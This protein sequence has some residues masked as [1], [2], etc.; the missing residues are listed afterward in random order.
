[1]FSIREI[2]SKDEW[3]KFLDVANPHTFLHSWNWGEF[4]Q[5]LGYRVWHV[6]VYKNNILVAV[7]LAIAIF[8]RR[9]TFIFC[10][11][12]PIIMY[13][14]SCIRN[15]ELEK[16]LKILTGFLKN[17]AKQ[18][19]A[20][21]IR[22]SPL[23]ENSEEQRMIFQKLGFRLAP[24]HMHPERAWILDIEKSEEEV[25]M[26]MRKQTRHCIRNAVLHGVTVAQ[27]EDV[28]DIDLFYSL[29]EATAARQNF[30]PFSR[31]YLKTEFS[32]FAKDIQA[33]IFLGRYKGE[34]ISGAIVIFAHGSG[35]YH[36]GASNPKFPKIP[37]SHLLQWEIIREAKRRGMKMY[38]FWGVAPDSALDH[39]WAGLSLFKKGFGG[40]CEEYVP[41]EDL[42]LA[43][44]YWFAYVIERVRKIRRRL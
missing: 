27:S 30:V 26:G 23:L 42:P 7:M 40:F 43:L 38:N 3:Q 29:Y 32:L 35:F 20:S 37:A 5:K 4:Q 24:I 22:V 2:S 13:K 9:S 16:I 41:A 6:G 44:S 28:R 33:S 10:P 21:F 19:R 36:H 18:E 31:E 1:M 39:P 8:A 12:G 11:H 14:E 17:I 15:Q 34:V 25:L